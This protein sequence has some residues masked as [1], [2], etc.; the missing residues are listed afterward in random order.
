MRLFSC[1]FCE[2]VKN[3]F[4]IEGLRRL[5]MKKDLLKDAALCTAEANFIILKNISDGTFCENT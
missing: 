4:F 3:T 2:I 5:L 1:E